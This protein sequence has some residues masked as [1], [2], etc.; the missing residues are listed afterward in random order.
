MIL[1]DEHIIFEFQGDIFLTIELAVNITARNVYY[2]LCNI[3]ADPQSLHFS[4][5]SPTPFTSNR[6]EA[7]H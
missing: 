2:R 7:C 4:P 6:I 1:R 5:Q 3:L